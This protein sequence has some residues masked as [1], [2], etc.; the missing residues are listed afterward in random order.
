M[1]F[2]LGQSNAAI[3][4]QTGEISFHTGGQFGH[5]G[6]SGGCNGRIH[7]VHGHGAVVG[8][9]QE[10]FRRACPHALLIEQQAKRYVHPLF[11]QALQH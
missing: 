1:F 7:L 3:S 11:E 9:C 10:P 8:F 2:S 5:R 6:A 4:V